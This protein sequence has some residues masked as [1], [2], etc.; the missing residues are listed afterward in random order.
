MKATMGKLMSF[1]RRGLGKRSGAKRSLV[2][3][4]FSC[5]ALACSAE[6]SDDAWHYAYRLEG[7]PHDQGCTVARSTDP[8]VVKLEWPAPTESGWYHPCQDGSGEL[9][10]DLS[11]P[12]MYVDV[13]AR[14]DADPHDYVVLEACR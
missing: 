6:S 10:P 9:C 14:G 4:L 1:G 13:Y 2:I 11:A 3:T 8:E 12:G 5:F 7:V